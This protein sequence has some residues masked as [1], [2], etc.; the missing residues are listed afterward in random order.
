MY[1]KEKKRKYL[2]DM[3]NLDI[4]AIQK[5]I[6][7]R[8]IEIEGLNCEKQN[9]SNDYTRLQKKKEH[10]RE[11][12]FK[13]KGVIKKSSVYFSSE[14]EYFTKILLNYQ[15]RPTTKSS[16]KTVLSN[17]QLVTSDNLPSLLVHLICSILGRVD[18]I[19]LTNCRIQ[20]R[21]LLEKNYL[22]FTAKKKS[23]K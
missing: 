9:N 15:K 8:Y 3:L 23:K 19:T 1:K 5:S 7:A 17:F 6:Y 12:F 20:M 4:I 2:K 16:V 18:D 14:F 10:N 13:K 22:L 11:T 21:N